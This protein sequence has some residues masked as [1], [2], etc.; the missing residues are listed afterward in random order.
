MPK[1]KKQTA[2]A[3]TLA[4]A[5]TDVAAALQIEIAN[6]ARE[7]AER[8]ATANANATAALNKLYAFDA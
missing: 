4:Q 2:P 3:V 6:A 1:T 8:I 5:A 7:Y